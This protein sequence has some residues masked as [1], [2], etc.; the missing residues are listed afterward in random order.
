MRNNES[1]LT[2]RQ[3]KKIRE[4]LF[5]YAFLFIPLLNLAVFYFYVNID[6]F[7]MAFKVPEGEKA[8]YYFDRFFNMTLQGSNLFRESIINTL[9]YFFTGLLI[10]F[11]IGFFIAYFLFKKI[12]GYKFFRIMI[13]FPGLIAMVVFVSLFK[14][15]VNGPLLELLTELM[16]VESAPS[17]LTDSKYATNTIIV[18]TMWVGFGAEFLFI[19]GAM[20]RVPTEV[21]EYSKL[22]GVGPFRE[23]FSIILPMIFPTIS[24]LLLLRF[25]AI[26]TVSGPILLFTEGA[27]GTYTIN[28]YIFQLTAGSSLQ[29]GGQYALASAVGLF[30]SVLGMPIVFGIR[31]LS[32]KITQVV[33]Y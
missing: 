20:A 25:T 29:T 11:P 4:N 14:R 31:W 13:F 15:I 5:V 18:F 17:L 2:A 22:D 23:L 8:F 10:S 19:G 6:S 30:F 3:K 32:N 21:L 7:V 24:T 33:E 27:Y 26:F 1:K 16:G 28:Y 9:K 12:R